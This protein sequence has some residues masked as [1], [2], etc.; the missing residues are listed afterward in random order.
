[1]SEGTEFYRGQGIGPR[2]LKDISEEKVIMSKDKR[3]NEQGIDRRSFLRGASAAA[4]AAGAA[5]VM[6]SPSP[7]E[8]AVKGKAKSAGYQET[9]HVKRAYR[10][11]QF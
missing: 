6:A 4:A 5:A 8:A 11:A 2:F 7:A 3:T 1:L 9:E 10:A